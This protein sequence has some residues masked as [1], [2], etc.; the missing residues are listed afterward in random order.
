MGQLALLFTQVSQCFITGK[1]RFRLLCEQIISVG[2]HSQPVVL[3]TGA[4]TGA[5]LEAQTLFQLKIFHMESA[6]GVIVAIGMFR[7]LGPVITGLMIAGRVGSAMAA[8]IGTMKVTD[9]IDA[10]RSLNVDPVDYLVKPRLQ[11]MIISMPILMLESVV[12]GIFAAYIVSIFAFDVEGAYWLV[13]MKKF[14]GLGDLYV[15]LIKSIVFGCIICLISCHQG[16][17]TKDGAVGVGFSTM[18]AMVYSSI[19]LLI[20]NFLLTMITNQFFPIGLAQ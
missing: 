6:G 14:L 15:A 12:I 18:R 10:L 3:I 8:E 2:L 11:A 17:S 13:Q 1:T 5:V 9:Q 7:E 20:V 16:M 4:F 19:A